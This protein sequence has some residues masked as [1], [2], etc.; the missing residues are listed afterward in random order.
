VVAATAQAAAGEGVERLFLYTRDAAA[1]FDRLGFEA[2]DAAQ[3][4][5]WIAEGESARY[6]GEDAT[7]MHRGL[8]ARAP[9]G[10]G[11]S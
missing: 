1:F 4:P 8:R 6:C 3:A 7:L 5:R 9:M 2:L 10:S 11:G